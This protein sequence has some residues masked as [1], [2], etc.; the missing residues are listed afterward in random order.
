MSGAIGIADIGDFAIGVDTPPVAPG[1]STYDY[2]AVI[3]LLAPG[4]VLQREILDGVS[5]AYAANNFQPLTQAQVVAVTGP[6]PS[7][8]TTLKRGGEAL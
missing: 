2:I 6:L 3:D 5:A 8:P 1:T 7:Y 4:V